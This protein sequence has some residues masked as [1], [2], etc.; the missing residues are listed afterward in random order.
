METT[1]K[2]RGP[3]VPDGQSQISFYLPMETHDSLRE[4]AER[5]GG[6]SVAVIV[7]KAIADF[8]AKEESARIRS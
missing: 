6:A 2:K 1:K 4:A 7:R 3:R 5:F 8:L